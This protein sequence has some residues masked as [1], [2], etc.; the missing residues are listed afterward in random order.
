MPLR[1]GSLSWLR[2][3]KPRRLAITEDSSD[4]LT[5]RI[6]TPSDRAYVVCPLLSLLAT[7]AIYLLWRPDGDA[8]RTL[9][10]TFVLFTLAFF[11]LSVYVPFL[12]RAEEIVV[13][14]ASDVVVTKTGSKVFPET[15]LARLSDLGSVRVAH[16]TRRERGAAAMGGQIP[17]ESTARR[18]SWCIYLKKRDEH[19]DSPGSLLTFS[20]DAADRELLVTIGE[21]ISR[22]AGAEL[23]D[24]TDAA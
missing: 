16:V 10:G 9:M 21:S 11:A 5:V 8:G 4:R 24:A 2:G 15:T 23:V 22:L 3:R 1:S 18:E 19:P 17:V 7:G 13:D 6:E 14:G 12:R 20:D